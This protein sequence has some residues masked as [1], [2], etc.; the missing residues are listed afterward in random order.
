MRKKA[1]KQGTDSIA[2]GAGDS[3][4]AVDDELRCHVK[5]WF[6]RREKV[7]LSEWRVEL[8]E[9]IEQT[10]SLARAAEKMDVPYRTAWYK[11]K[12][13]EESLGVRLLATQPGGPE[14]GRTEL[15]PEARDF[16]A[17]F[18]RVTAGIAELVE[19]RFRK[20]FG[21]LLGNR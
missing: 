11:L 18:R 20:E 13:I 10:G 15:T 12:D 7:S 16:I 4:S 9:A 2:E 8:L 5:V 1:D 21:D 14:G 6:D 17:R 19:G 3:A